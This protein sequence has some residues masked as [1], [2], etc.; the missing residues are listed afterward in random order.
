MILIIIAYDNWI[1]HDLFKKNINIICSN[2]NT[3]N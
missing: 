3:G 2:S 1:N